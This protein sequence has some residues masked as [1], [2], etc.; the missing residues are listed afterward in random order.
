MA[1][2]ENNPADN[3]GDAIQG[4]TA[5]I[6]RNYPSRETS[7]IEILHDIQLA[8]R[9]LPKEVMG[10]VADHCRVPLAKVVAVATFYGAFSFDKKGENVVRVCVGTACH[11]KG[12][13]LIMDEAE[14]VLE[15]KSGETTADG[16]YSL[17]EVNCVGACAMAPLI[18]EDERYHGKFNPV[19]LKTLLKAGA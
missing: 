14:R 3:P 6:C 12:A 19:D 2:Q 11:V 1:A 8:F 4:E 13:Q 5:A 17:E 7:L 10:T 18:L 15:I 9:H 16:K